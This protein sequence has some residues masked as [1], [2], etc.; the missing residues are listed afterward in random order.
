ME[1]IFTVLCFELGLYFQTKYKRQPVRIKN[2][3]DIGFSALF[4]GISLMRFFLLIGD[5]YAIGA[6]MSPFLTTFHCIYEIT[7]IH[8]ILNKPSIKSTQD[9]VQFF[10]IEFIIPSTEHDIIH[11]FAF[12][13]FKN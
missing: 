3:Q 12:Y 10:I 4:Y 9:F 11:Y 6:I 13:I 8:H 5:Y 1:W 7:N 2:S